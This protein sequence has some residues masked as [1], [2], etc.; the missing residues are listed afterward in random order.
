M[1]QVAGG[2]LIASVVLGITGF[3]FK[4]A[5]GPDASFGGEDKIGICLVAV[6]IIAG[7]V[8]IYFAAK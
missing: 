6:G 5:T 3:G 1:L 2:I 4:I 8:V 7:I